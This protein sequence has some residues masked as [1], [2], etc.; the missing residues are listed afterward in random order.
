MPINGF[1]VPFIWQIFGKDWHITVSNRAGKSRS[2]PRRSSPDGPLVLGAIFVF[3]TTW[4]AGLTAPALWHPPKS[5]QQ[6]FTSPFPFVITHRYWPQYCALLWWINEY[7]NVPS[8]STLFSIT[9]SHV[10]ALKWL[11]NYSVSS[12][13]QHCHLFLRL[14]R[15]DTGWKFRLDPLNYCVFTTDEDSTGK[16]MFF[17]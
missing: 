13:P 3:W 14:L 8:Q 17:A 5:T 4:V 7:K 15:T 6:P 16:V 12:H 11:G 1:L 9:S 2:W 10:P